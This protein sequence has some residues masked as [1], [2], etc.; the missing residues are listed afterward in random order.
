M[1]ADE[2]AAWLRSVFGTE[3][4]YR[5]G[6]ESDGKSSRV[7]IEPIRNAPIRQAPGREVLG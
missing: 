5:F 3:V 4:R 7:W 1:T 2:L 6:G